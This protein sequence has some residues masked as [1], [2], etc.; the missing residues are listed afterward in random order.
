[1]NR[2]ISA[3]QVRERLSLTDDD[4]VNSAIESAIGAALTRTEAVLNTK[5]Q[6]GTA[7]DVF[8]I[9]PDSNE[10]FDRL[11]LLR[12]SNGFI[13]TTPSYSIV[14]GDTLSGV[15]TSTEQAIGLLNPE[16][17]FMKVE[18]GL[19]GKYVKVSYSYGFLEDDEAPAWLQEV[20]L[21]Y[22]AKALSSQQIADGKPELSNVFAF[23][24]THGA[25]IMDRHLRTSSAAIHPLV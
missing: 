10:A 4:G 1:M 7:E 11:Y 20:V 8:F 17:G 14:V 5:I 15:L 23:L 22:T 21:G 24:D 18:E 9:N 16:K 6:A 25:T 13:K 2:I 12:L 3:T 19:Q